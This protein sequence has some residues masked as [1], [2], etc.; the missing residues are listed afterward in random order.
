MR[1]VVT[2]GGTGGHIY[3]A[4]AIIDKF[5]SEEKNLEVLYIGTH[6]RMEKDIIPKRGINYEMVEIYGL[7]PRDMIRNFK[8]IFHILNARKKCIKILK[9]FKPD[10]VLGIGGYVTYPVIYA[11]KKLGIPVFIHEQNAL[12][13]KTNRYLSKYSDLVAT[14]FPES[15]K[16]FPKAKR[17]VYTGHPS[18]EAAIKVDPVN[19]ERFGFFIERKLVTI[20][21]GS[22][23]SLSM[24]NIMKEFITIVGRKNYSLLYIT[25][26]SYYEEFIKDLTIPSNVKVIPYYD[27]LAGVMKV[28]DILVSRA[29]AA[30]IAEFL[31]LGIPTI[32]IPSPNVANN[33]QFF[34]AIDIKNKG[35]C[36]LIEEK[37]LTADILEKTIDELFENKDKYNKMKEASASLVPGNS[38]D[39]IYKEIKGIVK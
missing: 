30:T 27:P 13:G 31:A 14:S 6:N 15:N 28:T 4:L 17:V 2:A 24:N 12:P 10:V 1:I 34:N 19:V 9:E 3:P 23:G 22:L 32:L 21:G 33:H 29:G 20:V 18:G 37:D 38:L 11:A 35:A 7:S 25:G 36:E 16:Y 8:N 26:E 5:K 39:I